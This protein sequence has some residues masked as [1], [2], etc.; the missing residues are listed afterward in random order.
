[1][2][3]AGETFL[4]LKVSLWKPSLDGSVPIVSILHTIHTVP[5]HFLKVP[6][7]IHSTISY[8]NS[9]GRNYILAHCISNHNV[10]QHSEWAAGHDIYFS[11]CFWCALPSLPFV[12]LGSV[13]GPRATASQLLPSSPHTPPHP[14]PCVFH[15][16]IVWTLLQTRNF[17][18]PQK[19][20]ACRRKQPIMTTSEVIQRSI[21]SLI[22]QLHEMV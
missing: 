4:F 19:C 18:G 16:R 8:K 20:L 6:A 15:S 7:C 1:M 5:V 21:P 3:K 9:Y 22:P 2:G 10:F 14:V 17:T 13:A 11:Q 12:S